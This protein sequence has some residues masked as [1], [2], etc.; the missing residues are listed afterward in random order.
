MIPSKCTILSMLVSLHGLGLLLVSLFTYKWISTDQ[1]DIGIFG[2]CEYK[3]YELNKT[4]VSIDTIEENE[5]FIDNTA[6]VFNCYRLILPSLKS[7]EAQLYL[8]LNP[9][10]YKLLMTIAILSTIFAI[11]TFIWLF[12]LIIF[13]NSLAKNTKTNLISLI[14]SICTV[15]SIICTL[16]MFMNRQDNGYYTFNDYGYSFWCSIAS[17]LLF[18]LT[19]ILIFI[20]RLKKNNFEYTIDAG[21]YLNNKHINSKLFSI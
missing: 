4:T 9:L 10:F 11:F 13:H 3:V 17:A 14:L 16:C 19:T 2:I 18:L 12:L 8:S 7:K 20:Q 15:L 21:N 5:F 1:E 6:T